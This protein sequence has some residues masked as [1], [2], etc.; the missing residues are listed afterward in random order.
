MHT[1]PFPHARKLF[2]QGLD[3]LFPP[4]C[5][6]C[7]RG[8]YLLCPRCLRTMQP[9]ALPICAHCGASIARPGA[10]CL[11]CQQHR[12]RLDGLRCVQQYQGA[13]RNAIHAL[14]YH[15][16]R[17]LAE[18]LGS[19]LAQAFTAYGMYADAIVPL[20]LHEQRQRE[21]GYNHAALLARVCATHLNIPCLE[22]LV[23]RQRAT[24]AQVGLNVQER[25]QNVHGAF[26]LAPGTTASSLPY[27]TIV[28]VDDVSTTGSS[29]EA[30]ATPLYRSGVREVWGLVLG[31]PNNLIQDA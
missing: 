24:R 4:L 13:L 12:F 2:Q 30:C 20:P 25:Q 1:I 29:L 3:L 7:Q 16:Q 21:R 17:R 14:K 22:N 10:L 15:N 18:P 6:G 9:L 26:A 19:L 23:V 11:A 28:L 5:A 8:G 31:R 27:G